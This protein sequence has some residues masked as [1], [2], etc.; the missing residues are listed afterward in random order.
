[1]SS[2]R[3]SRNQVARCPGCSSPTVRLG[4]GVFCG[5][6]GPA[7]IRGWCPCGKD[8]IRT[9]SG[10]VCAEGHGRI[11]PLAAVCQ[12]LGFVAPGVLRRILAVEAG[13]HGERAARGRLRGS[14]AS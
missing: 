7:A 8:L 13:R 9:A 2:A 4:D 3:R 10:F 11:F 6:G 5:C 14:A 12:A 1:M